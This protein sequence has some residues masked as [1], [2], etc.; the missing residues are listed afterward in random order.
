MKMIEE[1]LQDKKQLFSNLSKLEVSVSS[2]DI[3]YTTYMNLVSDSYKYSLHKDDTMGKYYYAMDKAYNLYDGAYSKNNCTLYKIPNEKIFENIDNF[4]KTID[5][6][7]KKNT[8]LKDELK[9]L[10]SNLSNKSEDYEIKSVTVGA[11]ILEKS[12]NFFKKI[13]EIDKNYGEIET[14]LSDNINNFIKNLSPDISTIHKNQYS[15][16]DDFINKI[17]QKSQEEIK[18]FS[19]KIVGFNS[20]GL[21]D[22]KKKL[23]E[24][25]SNFSEEI[26][27]FIN[28]I[29]EEC[30]ESKNFRKHL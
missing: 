6:N 9:T 27:S 25:I 19:N 4:I 2:A 29:G 21:E 10:K 24:N 11:D 12:F 16:I 13:K 8:K 18:S 20:G 26:D 22:R 5:K 17:A 3:H 23:S 30:E 1:D 28:E 15:L 7:Q 14:K